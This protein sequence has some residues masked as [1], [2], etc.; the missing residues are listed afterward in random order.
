MVAECMPNS[1][2]SLPEAIRRGVSSPGYAKPCIFMPDKI[3]EINFSPSCHDAAP[4]GEVQVKVDDT[5]TMLH[6]VYLSAEFHVARGRIRRERRSAADIARGW[7][8]HCAQS[9]DENREEHARALRDAVWV[10]GE[11]E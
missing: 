10:I 9:D 1:G 8:C 7:G 6:Y 4:T 11:A 3:E 2:A 5:L